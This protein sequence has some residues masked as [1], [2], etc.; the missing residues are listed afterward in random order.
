MKSVEIIPEVALISFLSQTSLCVILN[1]SI[2]SNSFFVKI[3]QL[4]SSKEG[5]FELDRAI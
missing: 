2:K 3:I 1:V 4:Y 5:K